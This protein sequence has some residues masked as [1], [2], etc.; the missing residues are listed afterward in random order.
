MTLRQRLRLAW[1]VGTAELE[2]LVTRIA[3]CIALGFLLSAYWPLIGMPVYGNDEVHYYPSFEF[4]LREDGRWLNYALHHFLRSIAPQVWAP[5][6]VVATWAVFYRLVRGLE[7]DRWRAIAV[8]SVLASAP[9]M[10]E[11]SLW[12]A[13]TLPALV[14]LL[15]ATLA[16]QRGVHY[17]LVYLGAGV[18][19]F[20]AVQTVYFVLPL[21][22][23]PA[24]LAAPNGQGRTR[25]LLHHG[26]AWVGGAV[27]GAVVSSGVLWLL[28][29]TF[30]VQPAAWRMAH[31]ATD[32]DGVIRNLSHVGRTLAWESGHLVDIVGRAWRWMWPVLLI[33]TVLRL[34]ALLMAYP[35][36]L[37]LGAMYLGFFAFSVPLAPLIQTRSLVAMGTAFVLAIACLPGPSPWGRNVCAVLL[38]V[39]AAGFARHGHEYIARYRAESGFLYSALQRVL[40]HPPGSYQALMV[41]GRAPDRLAEGRLFNDPTFLHGVVHALGVNDFRD[42]RTG[43]HRDCERLEDRK[44][45]STRAFLDGTLSV[46]ITDD[47]IAVVRYR[48]RDAADLASKH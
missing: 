26:A 35:L 45:V 13:T 23:A 46:E 37:V 24:L 38:I 4:K 8:A 6:F 15:A 20:G 47:N 42:C 31:P 40:P 22:F 30:G 16:A 12:P 1:P 43:S 36:W 33:A 34:R 28:T 29:G 48:D 21:A 17:V 27:A 9:A 14:L 19:M 32:L 11:Q 3:A 44:P 7:P 10:I 5:L 18:L 39:V 25:L 41:M 2:T